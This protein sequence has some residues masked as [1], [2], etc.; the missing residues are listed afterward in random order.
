[1]DTYPV[2]G[3]KYLP[4]VIDSVVTD[5]LN[6]AGALVIEGPRASGKTMTAMPTY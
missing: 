1:M 6:T 5:S 4:R 2:L 3:H